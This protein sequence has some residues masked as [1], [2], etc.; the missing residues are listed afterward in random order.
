MTYKRQRGG[1]WTGQEEARYLHEQSAAKHLGQDAIAVAPDA[2]TPK[3]GFQA[4]T[5]SFSAMV[6]EL[7][8]GECASR[9]EVFDDQITLRHMAEQLSGRKET[10]RNNTADIVRRAKAATGGTYSMTVSDTITGG[11]VYIVLIVHRT[12]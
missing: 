12:A 4:K 8:P 3:R 7:A 6:R 1:D 2:A 10:L 11:H 5:A 9:A